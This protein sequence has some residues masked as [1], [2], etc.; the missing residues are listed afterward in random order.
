MENISEKSVGIW[1]LSQILTGF[2]KY[3]RNWDF[4]WWFWVERVVKNKKDVEGRP[5][6]E[7]SFYRMLTNAWQVAQ[8]DAQVHEFPHHLRDHFVMEAISIARFFWGAWKSLL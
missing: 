7:H 2:D 1:N 4:E 8:A 6:W 5:K 3:V